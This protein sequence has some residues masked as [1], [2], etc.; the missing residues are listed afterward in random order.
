[1]FALIALWRTET[2]VPVNFGAK[3]DW[4]HVLPRVRMR[5]PLTA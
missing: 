1:M 5:F 2:S 4:C 3:I